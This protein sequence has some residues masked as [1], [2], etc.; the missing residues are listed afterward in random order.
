MKS[1]AVAGAPAQLVKHHCR[2]V[3]L[4]VTPLVHLMS[5]FTRHN[6]LCFCLCI[7]AAWPLKSMCSE[8]PQCGCCGFLWQCAGWGRGGS[9]HGGV[10]APRMHAYMLDRLAL[11]PSKL[12]CFPCWG[13]AHKCCCLSPTCALLAL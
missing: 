6:F 8:P 3:R 13:V 1:L 5:G 11:R 2:H 7:S 9:R 4:Q 12:H 10:C